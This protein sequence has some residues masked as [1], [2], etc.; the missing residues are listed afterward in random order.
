MIHYEI[1]CGQMENFSIDL[2]KTLAVIIII[3]ISP[4]FL[5]TFFI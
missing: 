2:M 5:F 4:Q 3:I 1:D